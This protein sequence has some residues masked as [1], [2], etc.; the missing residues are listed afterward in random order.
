MLFGGGGSGSGCPTRPGWKLR[1]FVAAERVFGG[2]GLWLIKKIAVLE[3]RASPNALMDTQLLIP[4]D[5]LQATIGVLFCSVA[6]I[7]YFPF[8]LRRR[9]GFPCTDSTC[10]RISAGA[11]QKRFICCW[12]CSFAWSL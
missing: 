2:L 8:P 6:L 11:N 4:G 1:S 3:V 12:L 7:C 5:T 10:S 9:F